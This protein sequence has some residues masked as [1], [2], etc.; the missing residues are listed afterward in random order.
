MYHKAE[1]SACLVMH[2]WRRIGSAPEN[3]QIGGG[4]LDIDSD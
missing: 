4:D 2:I 3:L 1:A